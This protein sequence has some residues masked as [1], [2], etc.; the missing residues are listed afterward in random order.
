MKTTLSGTRTDVAWQTWRAPLLMAGMLLLFSLRL[1]AAEPE[2]AKTVAAVWKVQQIDFHYQSF[3]TFYSCRALVD[4]IEQILLAVGADKKSLDVRSTGCPGGEIARL[5]YVQIR[6]TS[7][8]EATPEALAEIEKTRSTRELAARVRGEHPADIAEQFPAK[9]KPVAFDHG[10]LKIE[11]GECELVEQLT[12]YVFPKLAIRVTK[13]QLN[14]TP[15]Q[16]SLSQPRLNVDA[17]VTIPP[18]SADTPP[19]H[20]ES[21]KSDSGQK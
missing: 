9:W 6:I 18:T 4:R 16:A 12:R 1:S 11:P 15:N 19:A 8:L 14:C 5:P 17:L 3:T 10:R 20:S 21:T 7:P 2:P 13:N